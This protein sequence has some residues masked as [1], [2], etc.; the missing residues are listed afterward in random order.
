MGYIITVINE[1]G[2]IGKTSCA[3]NIAWEL[4]E[5]KKVLIIDMDGQRANITFFADIEKND[6]TLTMFH[7][8]ITGADITDTVKQVGDRKGLFIIPATSV[9]SSLTETAKISRMKKAVEQLK[10]SYDY[11]IIDVNPTPN[12][13]HVL[14]LS[15]SDYALIP[16]L[17]DIASM[18]ANNGIIETVEEIKGTTNSDLKVLGLVFNKYSSRTN[19]SRQV[20]QVADITARQLGT[21]VFNSTIRNAVALSECVYAHVGITEYAPASAAAEDVRS[22]VK[23][24]V[25]EIK[26]DGKV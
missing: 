19:L 26:E 10:D 17:P 9:V 11:I 18:E 1:K 8:L 22:L 14:S 4:S 2:G 13:S 7:V 6:D 21:K 5:K 16:M 20:R 3:F 15:C 25:K 12:W 23:E 24:M